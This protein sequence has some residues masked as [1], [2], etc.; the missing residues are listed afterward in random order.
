M[1]RSSLSA[2]ILCL[3]DVLLL[4]GCGTET[5]HVVVPDMEPVGSGLRFVGIALVVMALVTVLAP[6]TGE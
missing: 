1:N 4:T 3:G 5:T 2:L 6:S